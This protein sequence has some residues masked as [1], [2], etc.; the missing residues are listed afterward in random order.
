MKPCSFSPSSK[1]KR[2]PPRKILLIFQEMETLKKN[3]YIYPKESCSCVSGKRNPE[4]IP[5][6]FLIFLK[7]KFSYFPLFFKNKFI[8]QNI[9]HENIFHQTI[10]HQNHQ[11]KFPYQY[12]YNVL[13]LKTLVILYNF[14]SFI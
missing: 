5:Y 1:N 2:N 9:L 7:N 4:N 14:L 10:F 8:L 11:T 13:P 12:Y 3:S 6:I